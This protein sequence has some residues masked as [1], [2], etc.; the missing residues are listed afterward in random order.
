MVKVVFE[1]FFYTFLSDEP[2]IQFI[3]YVQ[4]EIAR[5]NLETS[6]DFGFEKT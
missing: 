2:L 4:K 3:Q 1:I 5:S 6:F